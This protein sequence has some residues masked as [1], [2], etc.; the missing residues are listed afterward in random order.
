MTLA[1]QGLM[2][3]MMMTMVMV[4]VVMV[5]TAIVRRLICGFRESL[6]G[7]YL[8]MIVCTL[9]SH[10]KVAMPSRSGLVQFAKKMLRWES[11]GKAISVL[12][13]VSVMYDL[14]TRA[15]R[16]RKIRGG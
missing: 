13:S 9:W 3:M 14:G 7:W 8:P 1:G 5:M 16:L 6:D 2:M 4:M 11:P 12:Y 10:G 15:N